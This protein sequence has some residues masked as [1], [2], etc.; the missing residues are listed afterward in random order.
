MGE[1]KSVKYYMSP[2][3]GRVI[4]STSK[5]YKDLKENGYIVDKHKCLYDV[6]SAQRCIERLLSLYPNVVFPSKLTD[7]PKTY[8]DTKVR[9]FISNKRGDKII[10]YIDKKG[11]IYKFRKLLEK[12]RHNVLLVKDYSFLLEKV[13]EISPQPLDL[14]EKEAVL[15]LRNK[16]TVTNTTDVALYNPV[17]NDFVYLSGILKESEHINLLTHIN[18]MLVPTTLPPIKKNGKVAG[19]AVHKNKVLGAVTTDNKLVK[20]KEP[21][22]IETTSN[23]TKIED[24]F[25]VK[26][27]DTLSDT[28]TELSTATPDDTLSD[29]TTELSTATPDDLSTNT[30]EMSTVTPDDTLSDTRTEVSTVKPEDTLKD[31][32]KA[33]SSDSLP[34]LKLEEDE[35]AKKAF[36]EIS[37]SDEIERDEVIKCAD[38]EQYDVNKKRCLPCTAYNLVWDTENK[39]CQIKLTDGIKE[40][41]VNEKDEVIGYT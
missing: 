2:L 33:I 25:T 26:P 21:L 30:T 12:P 6:K 23:P 40:I 35:N 16:Q 17:Q 14:D 9:Y 4:K 19:L 20:L 13:V 22:I 11:K 34:V 7:I 28:T 8:K 38:G 15:V 29:T 18:N 3:S 27:D 24:Q 41:V 36:D 32:S 31:F 39:K 37:A 1:E 10:G 5:V